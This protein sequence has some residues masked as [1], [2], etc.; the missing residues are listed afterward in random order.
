MGRKRFNRMVFNAENAE[1]AEEEFNRDD[2]IKGI[3]IK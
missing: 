2:R 1:Y 3:P